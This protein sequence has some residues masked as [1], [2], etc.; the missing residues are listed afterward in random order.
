MK[1]FWLALW[2]RLVFLWRLGVE[3]FKS[4]FTRPEPPK[5][6]RGGWGGV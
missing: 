5:D 4:I 6:R 2:I 1:E 3:V